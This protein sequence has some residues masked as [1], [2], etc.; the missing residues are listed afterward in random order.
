MESTDFLTIILNKI[1]NKSPEAADELYNALKESSIRYA[2]LILKD[3]DLAEDVFH[4]SFLECSAKLG[5][6]RNKDAFRSWFRKILFKQCDRILRK[7]QNKFESLSSD[8]VQDTRSGIPEKLEE[9]EVK[10][11]L[12]NALSE[13]SDEDRYLFLQHHQNGESI[14]DLSGYFGIPQHVVRYRLQRIRRHL[15][16]NPDLIKITE[17]AFSGTALL[18]A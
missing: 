18:A 15:S 10:Y 7:K 1:E 16:R 8:T 9:N 14:I 5:Q 2:S 12:E 4:E 17:I 3:R 13:L 6:L 11:K